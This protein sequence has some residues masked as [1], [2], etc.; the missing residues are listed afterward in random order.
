MLTRYVTI[1]LLFVSANLFA[2]KLDKLTVEKIMRDPKW[3]DTSPSGTF[4]SNDGT[5]LYFLWNP[6]KVPNDSLWYITTTNKTPVMED[7]GF[8]EPSS[9]TDEH[10]RIFKLFETVLKK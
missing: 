4:C 2:Q 6:D 8:I 5:T 3:M 7:H 9:W 1:L 10:K